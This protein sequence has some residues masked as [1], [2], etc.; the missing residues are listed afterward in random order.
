MGVTWRLRDDTRI[1]DRDVAKPG[2][3]Q[4]E[5]E[6]SSTDH[7]PPAL[8]NITLFRPRPNID[9][10]DTMRRSAENRA[11]PCT[12]ELAAPP[13]VLYAVSCLTRLDA[14]ITSSATT[15]LGTAGWASVFV[16]GQH[17][18]STEATNQARSFVEN[19]SRQGAVT[20]LTM[21]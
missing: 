19:A 21:I 7:S 15:M 12:T 14:T 6:A 5:A 20:A 2:V 17:K 11:K 9:T 8:L 18:T 10:P 1:D 16:T 13:N 4:C 3:R